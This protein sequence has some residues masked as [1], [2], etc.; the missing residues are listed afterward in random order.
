[1]PRKMPKIVLVLIVL[2]AVCSPFMQLDSLDDF[3]IGTGDI[4][5][6]LI[7][8]LFETGMFFVFAG[9]LQLFPKL[10]S[11]NVQPPAMIFPGFSC[12][13]APLQSDFFCFALPLRI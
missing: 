4:E 3:P 2:M 1:M 12:D 7:S 13:V 6:H 11:T 8:V 9:I 10:L 5:M